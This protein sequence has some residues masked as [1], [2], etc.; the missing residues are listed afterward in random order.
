MVGGSGGDGTCS[1]IYNRCLSLIVVNAVGSIG[2]VFLYVNPKT[3]TTTTTKKR[4]ARDDD[5]T[6]GARHSGKQLSHFE[7]R[8]TVLAA[9]AEKEMSSERKPV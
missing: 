4:A 1:L 8:S 9:A 2:V 7:S 5:V 6:G 3:T